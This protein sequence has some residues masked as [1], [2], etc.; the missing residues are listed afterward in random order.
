MVMSSRTLVV[1]VLLACAAGLGLISP[2]HASYEIWSLTAGDRMPRFANPDLE[3]RV[4]SLLADL[5]LT[6]PED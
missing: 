2:R 6:Y 4:R 5:G 3:R 1:I